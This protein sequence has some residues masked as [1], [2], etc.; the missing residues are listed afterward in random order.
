MMLTTDLLLESEINKMWHIYVF[1][2]LLK[3]ELKNNGRASTVG[4]IADELKIPKSTLHRYLRD[5]CKTTFVMRVSRGRYSVSCY[6]LVLDL[7]DLH[8]MHDMRRKQLF[9]DF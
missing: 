8:H 2:T 5:L 4:E 9:F 6:G 7:K 3:L 1:Q